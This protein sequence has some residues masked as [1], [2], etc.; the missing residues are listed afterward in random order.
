MS[1]LESMSHFVAVVETGSI[2]AAADRLELTVAAVSKRL[3][4]LEADLGVRL[5]T[6]NTRQ[7]ALTEAGHYYYQHCREIQEEVSRVDQHLLAMQGRLSGSLR[8]NMPMTYGKLRL[9]KW[10]IRFLQEYP[11]IHL[12]AHLDDAYTDAASG[13]YDVVIR[14][15]VLE[16]SRLVARKLEN[17]YLMPVAAPAYLQQ[18]G[19]PQ[20]PAE[21]AQHQCLHYTN[22]SHREGWMFYDPSGTAHNVQ[23]RGQLCA[24]N[25]EILKQAAIAGM[26]IVLLPDFELIDSL[27]NGE[28]VRIL[29]DYSAQTVSVYAVYPSRQFLPEKTRV[30]VEFLIHALQL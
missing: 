27:E 12:T 13:D 29:P 10:L 17:V 11:D 4:L 7:L 1:R 22:V 28:L 14:I 5:L 24:N 20:T 9:S 2:T 21:L 8:I 18:H 19:T 23:I 3:K 30:L 15:G 6:R 26:G 16:D 25:G